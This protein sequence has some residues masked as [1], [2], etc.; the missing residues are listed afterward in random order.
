MPTIENPG[1]FERLRA[2]LADNET[3]LTPVEAHGLVSAMAIHPNPPADW[4]KA[5]A[6]EE[7]ALPPELPA[8]LEHERERLTARLGAGDGIELPCR[9]DPYADDE[10]RD[11]AAWC[12]G[13]MAGVFLT[14]A[15]W[16]GSDDDDEQDSDRL[17]PFL[18]ISGL[19]EDPALDELWEN[20][21]LVRQM[22]S[23]LPALLEELFLRMQAPEVGDPNQ[24]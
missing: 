16:P 13:F 12:T 8:V 15:D 4:P 23:G 2:L 14:E 24:A 21:T 7:T 5:V 6:L 3:L 10:G 19:D 20:E 18:L 9:L 22:T 17:L 11:L 1:G